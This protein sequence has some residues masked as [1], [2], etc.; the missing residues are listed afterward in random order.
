MS[1]RWLYVSYSAE[2]D[3]FI[4]R[5]LEAVTPAQTILEADTPR[6]KPTPSTLA[7]DGLEVLKTTGR[8]MVS[9]Y[10]SGQPV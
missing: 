3:C 1:L 9:L 4:K 7:F 6:Q 2:A 8:A 10:P 5:Q